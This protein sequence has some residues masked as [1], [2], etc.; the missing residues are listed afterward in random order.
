MLSTGTISRD[1]GYGL[2]GTPAPNFN[3]FLRESAKRRQ[4]ISQ[5]IEEVNPDIRWQ[6]ATVAMSLKIVTSRYAMYMG[7]AERER[8]FGELDYLLDPDGWYEEDKHPSLP[9]YTNFLKWLI[10]ARRSDWS[11]LGF[12]AQGDTL[13]AYKRGENLLTAAFTP[14]NLVLWTSKLVEVDGTEISSGKSPLSTFVRTA[15][16]LLDRF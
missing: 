10:E 1:R 16:M 4:D 13:A 2:P 14:D 6:L 9:S 15:K 7:F 3:E 8:L 5:Y 12:D 11:S